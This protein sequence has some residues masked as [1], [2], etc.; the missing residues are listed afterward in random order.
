[1]NKIGNKMEAVLFVVLVLLALGVAF[2]WQ[3][4][5]DPQDSIAETPVP[6]GQTLE[7]VRD[8]NTVGMEE[9][10]SIYSEDAP[11]EPGVLLC[12]GTAGGMPVRTPTIPLPR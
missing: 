6:Q 12:D 3:P 10:K 8:I 9:N 7:T 11:P 4:A 5:A 1:M 2:W